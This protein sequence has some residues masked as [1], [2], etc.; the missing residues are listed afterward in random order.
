MSGTSADPTAQLGTH[1]W[2]ES[3]GGALSPQERRRLLRPLAADLLTLV[4]GRVTGLLG[5]V[6]G[7]R[8]AVVDAA[9][10][11]GSRLARAAEGLAR[12]RLSSMLLNHSYRTYAFGTVLG[13][14]GG[15]DVDRDLLFAAA[16]LHDLGLTTPTAQVD[17]TMAGVRAA[18]DVAAQVGLSSS[19]TDTLLTAIT[20]HH[21]PGVGPAH[22]PVAHLLSAGAAVDVVGLRS[23]TLA[24]DVLT[25]V[26][27]AYPRLGFKREFTAAFRIE[28]AHVPAGRAAFLRRYGAFDL[29]IRLAPFGD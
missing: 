3:T 9:P 6:P 11:P 20:L 22:G 12:Q 26:T 29:A 2:L 28:A 10:V 4:A 17:F 18:R 19:A 23:W 5:L 7:R 24:P 13:R 27:T 25:D 14:L 15:L 21:S 1:G 16:M 8:G